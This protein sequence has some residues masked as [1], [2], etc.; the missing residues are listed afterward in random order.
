MIGNEKPDIDEEAFQ[1]LFEDE[2][3]AEIP[4]DFSED[5][6]GEHEG[7]KIYESIEEEIEVQVDLAAEED[8]PDTEVE[9]QQAVTEIEWRDVDEW[10]ESLDLD[11]E[12]EVT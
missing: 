7:G 3:A 1:E 4:L 9:F 12:A 11:S 10:L 5:F 2:L 8:L 6:L